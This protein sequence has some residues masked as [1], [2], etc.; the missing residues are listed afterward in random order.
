M[1]E[2]SEKAK[3]ET[4]VVSG[5]VGGAFNID[6]AGFGDEQGS[7]TISDRHIET[8]R[9][10][11]RSIKGQLPKDMKPGTVEVK[12]PTGKVLQTGFWKG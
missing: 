2:A 9:W 4:F 12:S 10:N 6:G 7:L 1:A 5:R 11:D 3:P 8:T